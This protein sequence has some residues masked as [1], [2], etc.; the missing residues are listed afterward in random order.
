MLE[1]ISTVLPRYFELAGLSPLSPEEA[2][3][4]IP[5]AWAC[6]REE[7]QE[8]LVLLKL[9]TSFPP[10]ELEMTET[11]FSPGS[12]EGGLRTVANA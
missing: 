6:S 5:R 11:L 4:V 10:H 12:A 9:E 1:G 3:T 2:R 7:Y 8:G